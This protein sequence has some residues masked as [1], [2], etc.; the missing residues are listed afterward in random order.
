MMIN[1][2]SLID[3]FNRLVNITKKY[4]RKFIRRRYGWSIA[5]YTGK[6][7]LQLVS[8]P[9][10]DNPILTAK[11]VT[12]VRAEFV[13]DPFMLHENDTWQMFFEVWNLDRDKGEIALATSDDA[14][15]WNYQ[16]V[17]I[18]EPFHLSYPY[19]FKWADE[20]YLIPES[21][22]SNSV[23]LYKATNFPTQWSFRKNLIEGSDFTDSSV[24]H[25]NNMWWL[26]T[27]SVASNNLRLYYTGN[28]LDEWIEHPQSP[29]VKD[30]KQIA[31]P[32]GRVILF[33]DRMIRYTQDCKFRYGDRVRAFE[34]ANLTTT[35]YQEQE[36]SPS[37][38]IG[39]SGSGWNKSGMHNIDPHQ[40][41]D[42]EWIACVDGYCYQLVIG[43]FAINL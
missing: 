11:S 1:Q 24:F 14:R 7:P 18:D 9:Q 30:D 38:V 2:R 25:Y 16:Q 43:K 21:A 4:I 8:D 37:F 23:R 10:I 34:I 20:Y 19:V 35:C 12:D 41:A 26:F 15:H 17:V 31:R 39:A 29:I 13:A 6:S 27:T 5:I 22:G 42:G 3:K 28:F 33:K 32:G 36:I 40:I